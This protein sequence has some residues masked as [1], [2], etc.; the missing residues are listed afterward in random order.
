MPTLTTLVAPTECP[1]SSAEARQ[2]DAFDLVQTVAD[3]SID[4]LLTS[5]P[6]WGLRSYGLDHSDKVRDL[7]D[8]TMGP[9]TQVPPY[10][11]YRK[12]GGILGLEP[13]PHWYVSHLVEFF[14]QTRRILKPTGS[15]WVNLGDTYF[16]R[17]SSIRDN[18]R[19]GLKAGRRRR[20]TPSGGYLCDKQLLMIPA[21]FAIAMQE[22][23]WILRNDLI[24]SKP[25]IMPR[26][27]LDRLRLSHEH[28]FH[29]VLRQ[30]R[31]RAR[32]HYDI[33]SCEAG[34]RDVVTCCTSAGN[35]GHTATFPPA[36][37]RPRIL[38]SC[39]PG[40][41]VLDPF[42]GTG[43]ALVEALSLGRKGL[44]FEVSHEYASIAQTNVTTAIAKLG[45]PTRPARTREPTIPNRHTKTP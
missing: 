11:W 3:A 20:R 2:G 26:P 24:W 9:S 34:R 14:A 29:F 41:V 43:R 15:M 35:G 33:K 38:S 10:E 17:W 13:Y 30:P 39:P 32:Y 23:G 45:T 12:A 44:G 40:G 31:G 16:A 7:W 22:D 4:L 1:P 6:F 8:A 5:P 21:R 42:C 18:G 27:E 37:L 19:Q 28:W 25:N 36:L